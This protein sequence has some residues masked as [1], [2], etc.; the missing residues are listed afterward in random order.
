MGQFIKI[1]LA[2]N[3]VPMVPKSA[4]DSGPGLGELNQVDGPN[5]PTPSV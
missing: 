4:L 1:I 2:I 5:H 3:T